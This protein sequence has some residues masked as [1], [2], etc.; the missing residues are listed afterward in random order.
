MQICCSFIK[1]SINRLQPGIMFSFSNWNS[2]LHRVIKHE[3]SLIL[4]R[5]TSLLWK[6]CWNAQQVKFVEMSLALR[7]EHTFSLLRLCSSFLVFA[8]AIA[9]IASTRKLA[10]LVSFEI[11]SSQYSLG[12]W[13]VFK[14]FLHLLKPFLYKS[15]LWNVTCF[16]LM[17]FIW[18]KDI[19]RWRFKYE[20]VL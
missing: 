17:G 1:C 9:R 3:S 7:H 4:E 13:L 20:S 8:S 19:L 6:C 10:G 16:W 2:Q 14:Y 11:Q 5:N 12:H 15:F 18:N